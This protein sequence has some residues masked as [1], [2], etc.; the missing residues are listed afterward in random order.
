MPTTITTIEKTEV[1][2][3]KR[4]DFLPRYIGRWM[5]TFET[6]TFQWM[7]RLTNKYRGG[8]WNFYELTNGGFYLALRTTEKFLIQSPNYAEMEVSAD[9]AGIIATLFALNHL[10]GIIGDK[11]DA[12]LESIVDRYDALRDFAAEQPESSAIFAIID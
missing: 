12:T 1:A 7:K 8:Y 3:E 6:L 2:E 10:M 5:L 9:A 4:L 11:D